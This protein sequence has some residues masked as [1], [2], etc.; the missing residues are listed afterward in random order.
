[1]TD[2]FGEALKRFGLIVAGFWATAGLLTLAGALLV[3]NQGG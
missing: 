2:T 1:M 3:W